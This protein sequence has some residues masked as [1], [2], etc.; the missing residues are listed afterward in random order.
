MAIYTGFFDSHFDETTGEYDHSYGSEDFIGYFSGI[1][2]SGVCVYGNPDSMK[3]FLNLDTPT[4]LVNP[5]YLF[6]KGYWLRNDSTHPISLASLMMGSYVVYAELDLGN[7]LIRLGVKLKPEPEVYTNTLILAR[8][9][10]TEDGTRSI[11]DTR[12]D[13]TICGIIDAVGNLWP[14]VTVLLNYIDTEI[15]SKLDQVQADLQASAQYLDSQIAEADSAIAQVGP[16]EVGTIKFSA[17]QN[18]DDYWLRCDGRFINEADYPS[19]VEALGK[20]T[21]GVEDFQEIIEA[22]TIPRYISN[23]VIHNGKFWVFCQSNS[24]LY[25]VS[26]ETFEVEE[27]TVT[28]TENLQVPNTYDIYLSILS[29][30]EVFLVQR[31]GL[32][33]PEQVVI[34]K[35]KLEESN[36]LGL[37]QITSFTF[38]SSSVNTTIQN[39]PSAGYSSSLLDGT[40][41]YP[42]KLSGFL[43]FL[44]YS[45]SNNYTLFAIVKTLEDNSSI[46][47]DIFSTLDTGLK[48]FNK[49]N[50]GEIIFKEESYPKN[51]FVGSP[52]GYPASSQWFKKYRTM[53]LVG[54]NNLMVEYDIENQKFNINWDIDY[55]TSTAPTPTITANLSLP[56]GAR[57][58]PDAAVYMPNQDL[59]VF[60]VG[61]GLVFTRSPADPSAYGYLDTTGL[62]GNIISFGYLEYN[63]ELDKL[64]ILGQD[65]QYKVHLAALNI[66][67]YYNYANDGT[68]LPNI[69]SDGVPAWIRA[70]GEGETP[71]HQTPSSP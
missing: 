56:V 47:N 38:D 52:K 53:S 10:V 63:S 7:R 22:G 24:K 58:F 69:V 31:I 6:I 48:G 1:V 14:R 20:L 2:G 28:G 21:P 36:T 43:V 17:S 71:P 42:F 39:I 50:N 18:I 65:T 61:T 32:T 33:R 68:W 45:S 49:K 40:D 11:T 54:G 66:P 70:Y 9:E 26:L 30:G 64:Y 59:W 37:T 13:T 29:G 41:G 12:E 55:V 51:Y 67:P 34:L 62:L 19:L 3:V 35:G 60:F 27:V 16:P 15:D 44:G 4:A 23:G 46:I 5:G 57:V 25:G 8:I